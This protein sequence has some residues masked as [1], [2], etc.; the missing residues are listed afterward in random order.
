MTIQYPT[1]VLHWRPTERLQFSDGQMSK[2]LEK[3][4]LCYCELDTLAMVFIWEY[5]N[6]MCNKK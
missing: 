6:D 4:L 3:A 2:A 1:E 5:L